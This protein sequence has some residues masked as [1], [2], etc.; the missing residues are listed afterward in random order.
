MIIYDEA[1]IDFFA[2]NWPNLAT[3][4]DLR[5]TYIYSLDRDIEQLILT[6]PDLLTI[7]GR[8]LPASP[9]PSSGL[10]FADQ[11]INRFPKFGP[12]CASPS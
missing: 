8:L 11:N 3:L 10:Y 7:F 1:K 5:V 2:L 12:K 9:P 6:R 4:Y